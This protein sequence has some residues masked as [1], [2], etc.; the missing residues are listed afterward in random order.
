MS[1]RSHHSGWW[2]PR[3][4]NQEAYFGDH[5][6]GEFQFRDRTPTPPAAAAAAA[7]AAAAAAAPAARPMRRLPDWMTN[8]PAAAH[9]A[10]SSSASVASRGQK[11]RR[12]A[13]SAPSVLEAQPLHYEPDA[14]TIARNLASKAKY[15][16]LVR[17]TK[18]R[19][20]DNIRSRRTK[21][22]FED[23]DADSTSTVL[24]GAAAAAAHAAPSSASRSSGGM[25]SMQGSD[26]PAPAPP[27]AA[28]S[29]AVRNRDMRNVLQ[30]QASRRQRAPTYK[31]R[32]YKKFDREGSPSQFKRRHGER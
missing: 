28:R 26:R 13:A 15:Q 30:R 22:H 17:R 6:Y 20:I 23:S 27:R 16:R 11:R 29:E 31:K 32:D 24:P 5:P 12:G 14:K 2:D 10:P 25:P 4:A 3:W 9:A 8:P 7:P 1:K 21:P 19:M 18:K